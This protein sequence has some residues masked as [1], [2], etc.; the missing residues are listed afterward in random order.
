MNNLNILKFI[1]LPYNTSN[2]NFNSALKMA[3]Y[4]TG[5]LLDGK[6]LT[7]K[8][9]YDQSNSLNG[10]LRDGL[11][12]A[13]YSFAHEAFNTEFESFSSSSYSVV[14]VSKIFEGSS[15]LN[16]NSMEDPEKLPTHVLI[17]FSI[18]EKKTD[19]KAV[20]NCMR[21]ALN[22]FM[23]RFSSNAI[24]NEEPEHFTEFSDRFDH[25]FK[26]LTLNCE[27]RLKDALDF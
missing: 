16:K 12:S 18:I 9:Y 25:I 21:N 7:Q 24:L 15:A 17:M 2:E 8:K 1:V 27:D 6:L 5:I 23:D 20:K 22:Q 19:E 3:I 13:V 11:L 10:K 14:V 4:E 26:D